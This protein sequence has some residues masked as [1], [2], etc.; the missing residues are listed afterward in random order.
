MTSTTA[1]TAT[2]TFVHRVYIK[3]TA[4]AIWTAITDPAWSSRYGYGGHVHYDL[5]PG[6]ALQVEP[7]DA[8]RAGMEAHGVPAPD[9]VIE[10]EVI[11]VDPPRLLK[12]TWRMLM[13]PSL[14]EEP[15]TTLTYEIK[16]AGDGY[17]SLTVIQDCAGAPAHLA[18][19]QGND[20]PADEGGGGMPWVLS[21]LKTLLET[22]SRMG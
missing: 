6:G 12:T 14:S 8:F 16:P 11:E 20:S 15:M 1:D 10:G 22:G 21:D 9:V 2:T 5:R 19:I 17:C 3:T 13:D 4:E 7:D 18:L